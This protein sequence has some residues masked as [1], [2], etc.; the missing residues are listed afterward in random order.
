MPQQ[1][2][3]APAITCVHVLEEV[4]QTWVWADVIGQNA[5]IRE[6]AA[7]PTLATR[8]VSDLLGK[9]YC[10]RNYFIRISA[11]HPFVFLLLQIAFTFYRSNFI[12]KNIG[13]YN[14]RH[15]L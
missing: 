7:E 5:Q 1:S 6:N 8:M 9:K 10:T 15:G 12:Q 14:S 11:G 13:K 4:L 2:Y 3:K